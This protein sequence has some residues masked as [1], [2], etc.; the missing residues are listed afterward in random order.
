MKFKV[1]NSIEKEEIRDSN[2]FEEG[3]VVVLG[4]WNS[5]RCA[6]VRSLELLVYNRL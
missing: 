3:G 1:Q 2:P 4:E 5:V 6:L